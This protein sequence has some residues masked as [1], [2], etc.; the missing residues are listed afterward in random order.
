MVYR[1]I[2]GTRVKAV[3]SDC[4]KYRYRLVIDLKDAAANGKTA[5]VI[6]MNPSYANEEIADRSVQFMERVV[7]QRGLPEFKGVRRLI[8][9]N[10]FAY[11]QTHQFNGLP[12]E[13]GPLNDSAIKKAFQ[14]SEIIIVGWGCA[15]PF[16]ERK[17]FVMDLLRKTRGKKLFR[18]K[19][20][21]SRA[22]YEGFIQPLVL[23]EYSEVTRL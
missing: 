6:M 9:V 3:F 12:H 8:V 5:C 13:I 22:G 11:I 1:H 18:T 17:S 14:E 20:H 19:K 15:N 10:Q 21:P 2:E 7:L 16:E 23:E 4:R